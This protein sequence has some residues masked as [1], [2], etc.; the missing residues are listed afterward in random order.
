M[1]CPLNDGTF[2]SSIISFSAHQCCSTGLSSCCSY[3]GRT[4]AMPPG[5]PYEHTHCT[6][7]TF[8]S[9][10]IEKLRGKQSSLS[11]F[12]A[13][14]SKATNIIKCWLQ[15]L[16]LSSSLSPPSCGMVEDYF[17]NFLYQGHFLLQGTGLNHHLSKPESLLTNLNCPGQ[18]ICA[19]WH[20]TEQSCPVGW[21]M[22][23]KANLGFRQKEPLPQD[24]R[25]SKPG[26]CE[27][28]PVFFRCVNTS[29]WSY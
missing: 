11:H 20:S 19:W 5:F 22:G 26:L 28:Q 29:R 24:M 23:L 17:I 21:E 25:Q 3:S 6:Q 13:L 4:P 12:N 15:G 27:G 18:G 14:H 16:P 1:M 9:F 8:Y 10:I 7:E 2:H